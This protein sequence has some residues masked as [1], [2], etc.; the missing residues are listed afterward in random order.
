MLGSL[1]YVYLSE[2]VVSCHVPAANT[3][4]RPLT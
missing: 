2:L 3:S 1:L 4:V